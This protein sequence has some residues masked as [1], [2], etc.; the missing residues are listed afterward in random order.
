LGL[1]IFIYF[2]EIKRDK[3][4]AYLPEMGNEFGNNPLR[5]LFTGPREGGHFQPIILENNY[6]I[7]DEPSME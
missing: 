7:P 4:I 6:V 3:L 2:Q 5:V 1:P